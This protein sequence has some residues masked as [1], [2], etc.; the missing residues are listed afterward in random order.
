MKI[1]LVGGGTL[2]HFNPL[3]AVT[4]RVLEES[5]KEHM[6]NPQFYYFG[7]R[8]L[9]PEVL[10]NM[11]IEYVTI[12]S[13]KNR[14][15]F[16][17]SNFTDLFKIS[18]GILLA[19]FKLLKIYPDVIF[20]KGGYD[21]IPTCIAAAILRIPIVMHDSDSIPGRA[22][23]LISRFAS[24]IA[25]SWKESLIYFKNKEDISAYTSQPIL[26]KY[27]PP[28]S[29][30]RNWKE[31]RKTILITGGTQGSANINE[32]VL[33]ILPELCAKYTVI[34][35]TGQL[36]FEDV[37]S[38]AQ[39]ILQN[40]N[41]DQY[42]VYPTLDFELIYPNVDL[43]ISRAGSSLFE[44]NAWQIPA[45][46][47]PLPA[48]ISRDQTTNAYTNLKLGSSKVL[49]EENLSPHLLLNTIGE[50]LDSKEYFE[51]M[52]RNARDNFVANGASIIAKEIVLIGKEHK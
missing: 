42:S 19:F 3:I 33:Q 25:V 32:V 14:L 24:R 1:V 23:L 27:S 49:L 12:P 36:T 20:S 28:I 11:N 47:I 9:N 6:V 34:H 38:R 40:Y 43:V 41:Q 21:S 46:V 16:S 2:G 31:G 39:I 22:S 5:A 13:G 51:S 30:T 17:F 44:F 50:I 4:E 8:N 10:A 35:Q 37:K 29:Y 7:E 26:K 48:S 52:T 18:F 45:I 15:Y